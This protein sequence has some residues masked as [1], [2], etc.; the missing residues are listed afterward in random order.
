MRLALA[1][2]PVALAACS[3]PTNPCDPAAPL[4]VQSKGTR[5]A[6]VVVDQNGAAV[7]GVA[8]GIAGRA[9]TSVSGADGA[10]AFADLPPSSSYQLVA[11]PPAPLVGGHAQT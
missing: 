8:V 5:I 10:F 2:I 3:T 7:S 1:V 4:D 11:T 6:G 9:E